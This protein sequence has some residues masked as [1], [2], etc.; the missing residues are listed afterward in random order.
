M[1]TGTKCRLCKT[2]YGLKFDYSACL[3]NAIIS[4]EENKNAHGGTPNCHIYF[5]H[6]TGETLPTCQNCNNGTYLTTNSYTLISNEYIVQR[7]C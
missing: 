3:D 7:K 6:K 1:T 4:T 2:G 5:E